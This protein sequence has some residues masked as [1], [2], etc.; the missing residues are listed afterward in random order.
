MAYATADDVQAL[1]PE[2]TFSTTSNPTETEVT[3]MISQTEAEI[4][5]VLRAVGY[6]T[7]PVSDSSDVALLQGYVTRRVAAQAYMAAFR[8]DDAPYKIKQWNEDYSS[9]LMRLKRKEQQLASADNA[10]R[11]RM[12]TL[13]PRRYIG[14]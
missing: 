1:V 11:P 7:I 9:F 2:M 3:T 12:S 10:P 4:N 8:G 5:G 6:T 13:I 14:D